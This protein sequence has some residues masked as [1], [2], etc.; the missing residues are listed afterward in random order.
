MPSGAARAQTTMIEPV[1]PRSIN[2]SQAWAREPPVA[3]IGSSTMQTLSGQCLGQ[4]VDVRLW[5]KCCLV[6]RDADEAN[7]GCGHQFLSGVN[8]TQTGAQAQ[9]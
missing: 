3:N 1:A 2:S 5:L 8:K 4:L 9:G 7:V 6:T